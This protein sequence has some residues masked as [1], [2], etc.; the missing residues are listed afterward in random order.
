VLLELIILDSAWSFKFSCSSRSIFA[1]RSSISPFSSIEMEALS[2]YIFLAWSFSLVY[3]MNFANYI[4]SVWSLH[5]KVY[6]FFYYSSSFITFY[7]APSFE[8]ELFYRF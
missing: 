1:L 4:F 6:F 7:F 5:Y 8:L 3:C 2:I